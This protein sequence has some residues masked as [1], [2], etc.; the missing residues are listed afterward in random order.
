M[1]TNKHALCLSVVGDVLLKA[2]GTKHQQRLCCLALEHQQRQTT[3]LLFSIGTPTKA[4]AADV[5]SG[6]YYYLIKLY[7]GESISGKLVKM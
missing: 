2:A 7:S 1:E 6:V 5:N 3:A 4:N